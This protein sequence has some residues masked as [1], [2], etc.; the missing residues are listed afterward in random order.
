MLTFLNRASKTK[1]EPI[2]TNEIRDYYHSAFQKLQIHLSDRAVERAAATAMGFPYLM[3]LIGFH[4]AKQAPAHAGSD[5][6]WIQSA[7]RDAKKDMEENVFTPVLAPLSDM[8]LAFL[9]AM[10]ADRDASRIS[11]IC[12]RMNRPNSYVQPYRARLIDA[13]IIESSRKGEVVFAIPYLSEY[14]SRQ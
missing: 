7:I 4:I 3:Q 11:D 1:L 12:K 5:E 14:L 8:D 13:G 6:S 9:R 10:S 2:R